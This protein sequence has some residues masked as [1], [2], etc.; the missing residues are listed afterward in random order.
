MFDKMNEILLNLVGSLIVNLLSAFLI[1]LFGLLAFK[2]LVPRIEMDIS[3]GEA[4]KDLIDNFEPTEFPDNTDE[5]LAVGLNNF[6]KDFFPDEVF[7]YIKQWAV[8]GKL[9]I[10]YDCDAYLEI[11]NP[12][13]YFEPPWVTFKIDKRGNVHTTIRRNQFEHGDESEEFIQARGDFKPYKN[14]KT[15]SLQLRRLIKALPSKPKHELLKPNI[16]DLFAEK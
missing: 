12:T 15:S 5:K 16:F 11:M 9:T 4:Y 8:D 1:S 6:E 10:W 13:E 2:Y 14:L 3:L 7:E